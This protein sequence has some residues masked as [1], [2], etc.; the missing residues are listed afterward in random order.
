MVA[1]PNKRRVSYIIPPPEADTPLLDLPPFGTAASDDRYYP[2]LEKAPAP[3]T[4]GFT[5]GTRRANRNPFL[6]TPPP[7]TAGPSPTPPRARHPRHRLGVS[8]LALDTSTVLSGADSPGGI[9]YTGGRD[10]LVASWEL[11]V[12]HSKRRGRRY[13]PVGRGQRVRWEKLGDGGEDWNDEDDDG[14][15]GSFES[16]DDEADEFDSRIPYEDKWE[17]DHDAIARQVRVQRWDSFAD[18]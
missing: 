8:S 2:L 14:D 3:V 4:N 6:T 11:H 16:S 15:F 13:R 1:E 18:T 10:G 17:V 5:N 7:S 9:L 12:P